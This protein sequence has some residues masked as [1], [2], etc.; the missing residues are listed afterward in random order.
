MIDNFDLDNW[1]SKIE[2]ILKSVKLYNTM[3]NNCLKTIKEYNFDNASKGIID[4][5]N[6]STEKGN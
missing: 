3:S 2:K 4:A 6:A 1:L 5:V